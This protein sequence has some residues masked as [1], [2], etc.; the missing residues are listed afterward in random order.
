MGYT[1]YCY[2]TSTTSSSADHPTTTAVLPR[3]YVL[4]GGGATDNYGNGAGNMLTAS[5]PVQ[6][7]GSSTYNGW[8]VAGKDH[9]DA[10][11]A[12]IT[13]YA[14]GIR[15]EDENGQSLPI[16]QSVQQVTG[17]SAAHPS[18]TATVAPGFTGVG[19]GAL[20]NY[21]GGTGNMLTGS[22]PVYQGSEIT[23][24][25]A[26]GKDQIDSDPATVTAYAIGIQLPAG[27]NFDLDITTAVSS[28]AQ[29]PSVTV[30]APDGNTVLGGGALDSYTGMGNILTQSAP[31]PIVDNAAMSWMVAGKDHLQAD[32]SGT[33]TSWVISMELT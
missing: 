26:T 11:P 8:C 5:Y 31:G 2:T 7:S 22:F 17:D 24:W 23:G 16:Q 3:G 19:G 30:S 29:H 9:I 13:A 33:V 27:I 6:V 1:L 18:A 10:D 25:T 15:I 14:I 32:A 12:T 4:T 20:D 28:P 21:G